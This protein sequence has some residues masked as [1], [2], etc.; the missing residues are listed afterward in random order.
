MWGRSNG[1][2]AHQYCVRRPEA[3]LRASAAWLA[4]RSV[5]VFPLIATCVAGPG[6]L[7]DGNRDAAKRGAVGESFVEFVKGDIE[8]ATMRA[9]RLFVFA[10]AFNIYGL[11][12][13]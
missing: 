5:L 13:C 12:N 7:R 9:L 10:D 1:C 3:W 11:G 2:Y 8:R 6:F 4:R